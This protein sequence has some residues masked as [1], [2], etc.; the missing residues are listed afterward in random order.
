[1]WVCL[2]LSVHR[3]LTSNATAVC[4]LLPFLPAAVASRL[5]RHLPGWPRSLLCLEQR[6]R[7]RRWCWQPAE[8]R[9]AVVMMMSA[10]QGRQGLCDYTVRW[11]AMRCFVQYPCSG[12]RM[13]LL[14][15]KPW[16]NCRRGI[17]AVCTVTTGSVVNPREPWPAHDEGEYTLYAMNPCTVVK[18]REILTTAVKAVVS[19][20]DRRNVGMDFTMRSHGFR[21]VLICALQRT[22][23]LNCVCRTFP[24]SYTCSL[25]SLSHLQ[26][27]L[28]TKHRKMFLIEKIGASWLNSAF[29]TM[30]A[31]GWSCLLLLALVGAFRL[32]NSETTVKLHYCYDRN[33][34]CRSFPELAAKML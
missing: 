28:A 27:Q 29:M 7:R 18:R 34:A 15:C 31:G 25:S 22:M 11:M 26:A 19:R 16:P 21:M 4:C 12:C 14:A 20:R 5:M 3:D 32:S 1:M 24:K 17:Y 8:S 33:D 13:M 2:C 10:C 30:R 9:A 23:V 6:R